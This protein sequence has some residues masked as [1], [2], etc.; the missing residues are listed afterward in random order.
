MKI[1]LTPSPRTEFSMTSELPE[2]LSCPRVWAS[3]LWTAFPSS[4]HVIHF[5]PGRW[6]LQI[7]FIAGLLWCESPFFFLFFLM[8]V[9]LLIGLALTSTASIEIASSEKKKWTREKEVRWL[10]NQGGT[11]WKFKSLICSLGVSL[12]YES[13]FFILEI[14]ST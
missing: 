4:F 1:G 14:T 7:P 12:I 10:H 5:I 3:W 2:L 9:F 6:S 11:F 13:H 8:A